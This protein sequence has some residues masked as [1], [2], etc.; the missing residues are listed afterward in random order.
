MHLQSKV[1]AYKESDNL[2]QMAFE[3]KHSNTFS[4]DGQSK[5]EDS[6]VMSSNVS[7]QRSSFRPSKSR[8][9]DHSNAKSK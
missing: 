5:K 4:H 1:S 9:T 8:K 7:E 2:F 3:I 6:E